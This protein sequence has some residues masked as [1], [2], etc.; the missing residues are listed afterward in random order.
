MEY[1]LATKRNEALT[2]YNGG[3]DPEKYAERPDTKGH[4]LYNPTDMKCSNSQSHR[5]KN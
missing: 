1:G 2:R 5:D 3:G 4:I